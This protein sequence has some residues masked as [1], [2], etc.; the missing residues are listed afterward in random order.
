[1]V[2]LRAYG[3]NEIRVQGVQESWVIGKAEMLAAILRRHQSTLV[4]TY[5]R[6]GLNLNQFVFIGML[7]VMPSIAT[8]EHRAFFAAAVFALLIFMLWLHARF[9]PN[10]SIKMTVAKPSWFAR[11]WP[12]LVSWLGAMTASLIAAF[13]FYWLTKTP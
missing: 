9:I 10:A 2:E 3:E 1:M 6:F 13:L 11:I 7:V 8:W 12:S 5:K 4:T